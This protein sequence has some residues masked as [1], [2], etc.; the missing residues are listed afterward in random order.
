MQTCYK[1]LL[2]QIIWV[3]NFRP[4]RI[5]EKFLR[6]SRIIL[7]TEC[8]KFIR[9][10]SHTVYFASHCFLFL[11]LVVYVFF[12]AVTS[13]II[14]CSLFIYLFRFGFGLVCCFFY[15]TIYKSA[16]SMFLC[17]SLNR[18]MKRAVKKLSW[19]GQGSV[20][21]NR[22]IWKRNS[23]ILIKPGRLGRKE[24]GNT[25]VH[26]SVR[27][28]RAVEEEAA[29]VKMRWSRCMR[30]SL[31][32][33]FRQWCSQPA[34]CWAVRN[35]RQIKFKVQNWVGLSLALSFCSLVEF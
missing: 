30:I 28:K 14:N 26:F 8:M 29:I 34:G 12:Y 25:V 35:G 2:S 4:L 19:A 32:I 6:I 15:R 33:L 5:S 17:R 20:L 7:R 13:G 16:S 11:V 24:L 27:V 31:V 10:V 9:V 22:R 3:R 1:T 21:I 18:T 23:L